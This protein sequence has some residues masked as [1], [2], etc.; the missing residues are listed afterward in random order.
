[1]KFIS[2]SL[3]SFGDADNNISACG[4]SVDSFSLKWPKN[5]TDKLSDVD[6]VISILLASDHS[7]DQY[8]VID[9]SS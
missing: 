5:P 6:S 3:S 9:Y 7:S 1:V 4:G 8:E 2:Q